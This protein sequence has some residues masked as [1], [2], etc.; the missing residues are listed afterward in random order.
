[1]CFTSDHDLSFAQLAPSRARTVIDALADR[2]TE[3]S[4]LDGVEYVFCFENR[5]EEIG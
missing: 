5:G 3:L 4:R 2:T 1:V